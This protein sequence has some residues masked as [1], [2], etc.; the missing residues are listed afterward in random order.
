MGY[1]KSTFKLFGKHSSR[2]LLLNKYGVPSSGTTVRYL[3]ILPFVGRILKL[4]YLFLG[5]AVGGGVAI[6]NVSVVSP[7]QNVILIKL[8]QFHNY[9]Q[10]STEIRELQ[11]SA[12]R[13]WLAE[14][15]HAGRGRLRLDDQQVQEALRDDHASKDG[16]FVSASFRS[17]FHH[18]FVH[19]KCR[20]VFFF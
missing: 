17:I 14:R 18:Q 11:E 10:I 15:V 7:S 5:S 13:P 3:S 20:V 1:S 4:R 6:S 9:T 16:W 12:A 19:L 2:R 8:N